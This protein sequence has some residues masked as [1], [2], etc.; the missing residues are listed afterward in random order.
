MQTILRCRVFT[1]Q[2]SGETPVKHSQ[3]RAHNVNTLSAATPAACLSKNL[4]KYA[5]KY[6][7]SKYSRHINKSA[8]PVAIFII[9][10]EAFGGN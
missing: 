3:S 6:V 7:N 2:L 1:D 10:Q 5:Q 8:K 4:Q 9:S